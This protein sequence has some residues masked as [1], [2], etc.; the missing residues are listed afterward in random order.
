MFTKR[1]RRG[2]KMERDVRSLLPRVCCPYVERLSL[3]LL[4]STV[5]RVPFFRA[6][7]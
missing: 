4:Q 1:N 3:Q 6:A 2:N 7:H 5:T